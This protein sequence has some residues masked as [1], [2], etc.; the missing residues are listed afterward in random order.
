MYQH[1]SGCNSRNT[2]NQCFAYFNTDAKTTEDMKSETTVTYSVINVT[3]QTI[4]GKKK[5]D[6]NFVGKYNVLCFIS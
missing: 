2:K 1:F 5:V 4:L 6:S 3:N